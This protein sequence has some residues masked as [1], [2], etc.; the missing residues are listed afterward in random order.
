RTGRHCVLALHA[1]LVF[2]TKFRLPVFT[3]TH[4]ERA[5]VWAALHSASC[6]STS[7]SR[8]ARSEPGRRWIARGRSSF[9]CPATRE[10]PLHPRPEGPSTADEPV[11][12]HLLDR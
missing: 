3:G 9:P 8:T 6:A 5:G 2:V 1:H 12:E 11:A 10:G 4:L 7:S